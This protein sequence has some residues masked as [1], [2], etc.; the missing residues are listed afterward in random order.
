[1]KTEKEKAMLRRQT[2][3]P[4]TKDPNNAR[5][6]ERERDPASDEQEM[7]DTGEEGPGPA[8]MAAWPWHVKS[9]TALVY[10]VR[11]PV[12]P[13][14]CSSVV[15]GVAASLCHCTAYSACGTVLC[16]ESQVLKGQYRGRRSLKSIYAG[17]SSAP[18]CAVHH[19]I[20]RSIYAACVH[21]MDDDDA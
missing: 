21:G 5:G 16:A 3:E 13:S 2:R 18:D 4:E 9:R 8:L 14:L 1:M 20:G 10:P 7:E 17:A 12:P 6:S 15:C 11:L 19:P